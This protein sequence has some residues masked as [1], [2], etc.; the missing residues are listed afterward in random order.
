MRFAW[1]PLLGLLMLA[2]SLQAFA[3][4]AMHPKYVGSVDRKSVV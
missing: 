4:D 2:A 3:A 1:K